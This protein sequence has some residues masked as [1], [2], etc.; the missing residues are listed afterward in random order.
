[1]SSASTAPLAERMRPRALAEVVGQ[2]QLLG[3]GGAL[4]RITDGG[5]LPSLVLWGPP[6]SGKTTIAR[7]LAS[8]IGAQFL[9]I[10]AVLGGVK[11]IREAVQRAS[12][13]AEETRTVLFIDEIHRFNKAQQD[14]LLPHVEDGTVILIGATTENPS[15]ALN[16]ALLSR[17]RVFVLQP[18]DEAALIGLMQRAGEDTTDRGLGARLPEDA[19][20]A[21]LAARSDGDARRALSL[22]ETYVELRGDSG[23]DDPD[24]LLGAVV[25]RFDKGGDQFYDQISA[26]HKAVRG[27][28]P[29]GAVYW[30]RRML[31]GGADPAYVARRLARMASEDI[32]LADPRALQLALDGWA[33]FERLGSPEGER[34]LAQ[35]AIYLASVPKSNAVYRAWNRAGEA[36]ESRGTVPVPEHLRNAPTALA[37]SMGHGKGYRYDHDEADH[38]AAGQRFLPPGIDGPF[39]EPVNQ[40]LEAKIAERLARIGR[41]PGG[42]S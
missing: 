18:L 33:A 17:L 32:G 35:V 3:A 14:A 15:F 7:L 42:K 39:Y 27:S 28:D 10:S 24:R 29:D 23:D 37:K 5:F 1:M 16:N 36:V 2:D 20:L 8:E 11:D 41:G 21:A 4:G 26:L 22:L 40:G 9:A 38:V 19:V 12:A 13:A 34:A 6:G 30:L 25:R 31:D